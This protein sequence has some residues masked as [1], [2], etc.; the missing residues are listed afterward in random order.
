MRQFYRNTENYTRAHRPQNSIGG[1]A[2][3]WILS[4]HSSNDNVAILISDTE[5]RKA[6]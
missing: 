1:L 5:G 6:E 4:H 2:V 3:A